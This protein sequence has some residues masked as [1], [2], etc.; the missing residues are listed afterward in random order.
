[1]IKLVDILKEEIDEYD[2]VNEE[3]IRSF[4]TFLKEYKQVLSEGCEC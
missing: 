1:M 4:V 2:V 3:D